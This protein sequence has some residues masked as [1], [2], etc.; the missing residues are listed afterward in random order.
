[1]LRPPS[2]SRATRGA[3]ADPSLQ[4][5]YGL[6]LVRSDRARDAEAVFTRM[7]AD[8]GDRA[9]VHVILGQAHAQQGNFEAAVQDLE[10]AR[11]IKA[12]V[13]TPTRRWASSI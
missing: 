12:D 10:R 2:C 1:M 5:T 13:P 7:L 9:E 6:A 3:S 4:Y 11:G 8:H